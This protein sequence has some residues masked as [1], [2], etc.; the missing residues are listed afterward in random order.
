MEIRT[1]KE[2]AALHT[3]LTNFWT[4][5]GIADYA[6]PEGTVSGWRLNGYKLTLEKIED[7]TLSLYP[8]LNPFDQDLIN[9]VTILPLLQKM[10]TVVFRIRISG[11]MTNAEII[12]KCN[13]VRNIVVSNKTFV[14]MLDFRVAPENPSDGVL[15]KIK[16]LILSFNKNGFE[17]VY[18]ASGAYPIQIDVGQSRFARWDRHLWEAVSSKIDGFK[19]GYCDYT[20][21]SP[22]WEEGPMIRRGKVAIRYTVDSEWL[23]LKGNDGTKG[24]SIRLSELMINLFKNDFRDETYSFGDKLIADRANPTLPLEQKK[25]GGETHL[26]EGVNHHISFVIKENY[27]I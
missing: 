14:V 7:G 12:N 19:I 22:L 9:D 3:T 13:K 18:L 16:D 26:L 21:V 6:S 24:E 15:E 1:E 5:T 27:S 4:N 11:E 25:G 23:V 10:T 17:S 20:V 2:H 8:A